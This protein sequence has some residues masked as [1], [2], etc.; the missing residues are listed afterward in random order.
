MD[1]NLLQDKYNTLLKKVAKMRIYQR[2][3]F[4]YRC[5]TDLQAAKKYEREV[6]ALIK[7][8]YQEQKSPQKSLFH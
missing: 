6:D 7:A 8:E 3:Y 2:Q 5:S 1:A 4:M